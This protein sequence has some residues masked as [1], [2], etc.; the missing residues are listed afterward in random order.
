V[1]GATSGAGG[2]AS[3]HWGVVV[4]LEDGAV[5][6][7]EDPRRPMMRSSLA[8]A[9]PDGAQG[10]AWDSCN[11]QKGRSGRQAGALSGADGISPAWTRR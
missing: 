4:E 3:G 7:N 2:Q 6:P 11:L 8:A 5:A 10:F 1:G 9:K